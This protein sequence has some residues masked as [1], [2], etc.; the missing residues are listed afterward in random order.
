MK[1]YL[2]A[3]VCG[4][5]AGVIQVV[6]FAK[7]FSCCLLIPAASILALFLER[8]ANK[9]PINLTY[10]VSK[11]LIIGLIT[12]LYAAGFGSFFDLFITYITKNNDLIATLPQLI[13]MISELPF[14]AELKQSLIDLYKMI[15]DE[16]ETS[17]FS[18][19]YTVSILFSNFFINTI[20]GMLGGLLG[21]Q[22]INKQ[23]KDITDRQE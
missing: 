14:G 22:I 21:V 7:T 3:L 17:G 13:K 6:P 8:K 5:G 9:I 11:G 16:I 19:M 2:S 18:L 10:P 20:F 15:S 23:A 1:K 4:F 12:G